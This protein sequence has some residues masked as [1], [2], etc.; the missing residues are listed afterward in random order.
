MTTLTSLAAYTL[1]IA[2]VAAERAVELVLS[3]R[4]AAWSFA[5]GGR[6]Y[7]RAH[8]RVMVLAQTLLLGGCTAEAWLL[9]RTFV[10][11]LG[12]PMI[13]VALAAQALRWWVV[14]TLG[15]Q[16]NTRVIVVPGLARV[17]TGPFRF[18]RHPNYAAVAAEG[19]ALPLVHSAWLTAL[20]F[21]AA[22]AALL[23]VRVRCE[24]RALLLLRVHS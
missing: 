23:A 3:S 17:R 11:A 7:G 13:A 14:A 2:A 15:R 4:N 6:E 8:Y 20:L 21:S 22:N 5:R 19:A 18:L 9:E 1:L 10:P 16:W 12:I 24:E